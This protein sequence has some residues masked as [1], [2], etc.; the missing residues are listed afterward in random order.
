M[1][2]QPLPP[3]EL[4]SVSQAD[5]PPLNPTKQHISQP[6]SAPATPLS[7]HPSASDPGAAAAGGAAG[8]PDGSPL[9]SSQAQPSKPAISPA[10]RA[11]A[12]RPSMVKG[13]RSKHAAP[14]A[15]PP[16]KYTPDRQPSM[17]RM[18]APE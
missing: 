15:P 11:A 14:G 12:L 9:S 2:L 16:R 13:K 7:S 18:Y 1:H 3:T 10:A 8:T 6:D 17:S 4:P 5:S